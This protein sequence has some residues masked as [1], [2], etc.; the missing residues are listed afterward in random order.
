MLL[1]SGHQPR[2][3]P[4]EATAFKT[5]IIAGLLLLAAGTAE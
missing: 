3:L 5:P 4:R 2:V 1:P